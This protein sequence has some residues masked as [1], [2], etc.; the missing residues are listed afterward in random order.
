MITGAGKDAEGN[1]LVFL[2]LTDENVKRLQ[3]GDPLRVPADRL[4]AM[5]LPAITVIATV[6]STEVELQEFVEQL[7]QASPAAPKGA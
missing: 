6:Y 1:P 5:G 7:K 4:A 3:A 2:G